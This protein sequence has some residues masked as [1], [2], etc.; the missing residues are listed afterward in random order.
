[1]KGRIREDFLHYVWRVK[2]FDPRNLKTT[3]NETLQI[4]SFGT[5]NHNAGPDF[6]DARISL[7]GQL[8]AGHIEMHVRSSEWMTHGHNNDRNYDNVVLHVV[9]EEN[10]P[11]YLR[12][13]SRLP[14]LTLKHRIPKSALTKY[15]ELRTSDNW[16][17]CGGRIHLVP[18]EVVALAKQSLLAQRLEHKSKG[19][20]KELEG[21]N[22]D[23]FELSYQK[24]AW[25]FGLK[26]NAD[27]FSLLAKALPYKVVKRHKDNI[28]QLEA[29]IFGVSGM[30]HESLK[31]PY[32]KGLI[33]EFKFLQSKYSLMPVSVV[34]WKFLRMRPAGF[35]TIR[36]AQLAAF[37]YNVDR[38]DHFLDE[39]DPSHIYDSLNVGVSEYWQEHYRFDIAST[40]KNKR[41]GRSKIEVILINACAPL[42]FTFGK[43]KNETVYKARAVSLLESLAPENNKIVRGWERLGIV[44][45]TASDSQALLHLKASYCD[46]FGCLRCS[47][48]HK[49]ISEL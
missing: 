34:H 4:V 25:A 42:L 26:V 15:Y 8:W 27:G 31:D 35:P 28:F 49:L 40:K 30:L 36:L 12:D 2:H 18:D 1:M 48:G 5:Y 24:M 14:C 13:G 43:L 39:F 3:L 21:L 46:N 32:A 47:I 41:L 6:L 22:G 29:L 16:V 19:L 17:P 33:K 10:A 20:L 37:I 38:I 9:Y 44:S 7:N 11:I 23:F 45:Q